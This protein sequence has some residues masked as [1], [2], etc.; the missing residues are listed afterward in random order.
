LRRVARA[1]TRLAFRGRVAAAFSDYLVADHSCDE[2]AAG[3]NPLG[4]VFSERRWRHG[5]VDIYRTGWGPRPDELQAWA[6][7]EADGAC[8]DATWFIHA[9][10]MEKSGGKYPVAV[11]VVRGDA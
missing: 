6:V 10:A 3:A 4:V 8:L 11:S 9:G 2:I 7:L 5:P 1:K